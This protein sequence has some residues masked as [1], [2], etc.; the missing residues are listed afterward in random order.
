[1]DKRKKSF[2]IRVTRHW[3]RLLRGV[4]DAPS[5]KTFKVRLV[6]TLSNTT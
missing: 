3:S 4:V 2:I 5:L 1:M 6:W